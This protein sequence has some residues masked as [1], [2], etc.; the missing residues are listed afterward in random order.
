MALRTRWCLSWRGAFALATLLP[1]LGDASGMAVASLPP[2]GETSRRRWC[3]FRRL[4]ASPEAGDLAE[5]WWP[6]RCDAGGCPA[7]DERRLPMMRYAWPAE[8]GLAMRC[9]MS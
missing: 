2:L 8:E 6:P 1:S 4:V 7:D 9:V 3:A 5:G